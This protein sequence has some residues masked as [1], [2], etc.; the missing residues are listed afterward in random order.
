MGKDK[1]NKPDGLRR[2]VKPWRELTKEEKRQRIAA[3]AP[4][5]EWMEDGPLLDALSKERIKNG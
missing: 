2:G 4:P 3:D 5:S 1:T